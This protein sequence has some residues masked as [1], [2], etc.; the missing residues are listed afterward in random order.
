MDGDF[1]HVGK[2]G[3][4]VYLVRA[5]AQRYQVLGVKG[6]VCIIGCVRIAGEDF[7]QGDSI[8]LHICQRLIIA[9]NDSIF[10]SR[11]NGHVRDA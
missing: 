3:N 5:S 9:G 1:P 8:G 4:I 11:F 7:T 10:R 6:V 2:L